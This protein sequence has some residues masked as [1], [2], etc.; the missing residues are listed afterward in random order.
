M[1]TQ[2]TESN[3]SIGNKFED[4]ASEYLIKKGYEII[5]RNFHFGKIAEI[6]IIAKKD[7][8]I[9]FFEVKARKNIEFGTI[10]DS[11]PMTKRKAVRKAAEGYLYI[12]KIFDTECRIDF[13]GIDATI[14]PHKI[15]HIENAF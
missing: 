4:I 2:M 3:R 14:E 6:D 1:Q 10:Y 7:N 12:N 8:I 5:K 11:M 9:V 15:I 13:I